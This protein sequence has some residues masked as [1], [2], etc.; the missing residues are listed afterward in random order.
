MSGQFPVF[1]DGTITKQQAQHSDFS[2]SRTSSSYKYFLIHCRCLLLYGLIK[3]GVSNLMEVDM[4]QEE[5]KV[6]ISYK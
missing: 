6:T 5:V 2:E 4:I 1:L 3:I